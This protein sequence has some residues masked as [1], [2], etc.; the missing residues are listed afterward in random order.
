LQYF[1]LPP[2]SLSQPTPSVTFAI[3]S[4]TPRNVLEQLFDG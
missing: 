3:V 1:G 2:F 4:P